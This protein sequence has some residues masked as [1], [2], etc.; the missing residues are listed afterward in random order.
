M[1]TVFFFVFGCIIGSFL[2]VCIYR[3]PKNGSLIKPNS[4][5]PK[6][7]TPIKWY[8]NIPLLSYLIL[9]ARCR[10]CKE[11]I[12]I[13]YFIIELITG[14]LFTTLFL[15]FDISID[16]F[17][18]LILFSFLI[19]IAFIDLETQYIF[20]KT[21]IPLA[22]IGVIYGFI[23][24]DYINCLLGVAVG[25]GILFI[26]GLISK[27]I[28]KQEGMGLGDVFLAGAIGA[29]LGWRGVIAMLMLSFFIGALIGGILL[30]TKIKG[31]KDY[32]PFGPFI[33]LS[34]ILTV[35][36][37]EKMMCVLMPFFQN[38]Q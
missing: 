31:R 27:A 1:E 24:S 13:R 2:N 20:N 21:S 26:I 19:V 33:A 5:C 11:T 22:V 25:A 34:C 7:K 8:D 6:C 23:K 16:L 36:Y 3:I 28:F 17:F 14:I 15:K 10:K 29:F 30:L 4:F 38:N 35:L 32:I 18:N 12:S 9:R 37:S